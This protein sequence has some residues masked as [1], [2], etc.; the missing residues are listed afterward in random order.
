[1]EGVQFTFRSGRVRGARAHSSQDPYLWRRQGSSEFLTELETKQVVQ[2]IMSLLVQ[3]QGPLEGPPV[4]KKGFTTV[5]LK[6]SRLYELTPNDKL[7]IKNLHRFIAARDAG[8]AARFP[9]EDV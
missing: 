1:M 9:R 8:I 7:K 6:S 4:Q 3:I 5:V 2:I